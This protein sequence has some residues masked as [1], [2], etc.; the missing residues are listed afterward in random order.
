V[1]ENRVLRR[2]FVPKGSEVRGE[3]RKL[4][5]E[6]LNDQNS[7]ANISWVVRSR[8]TRWVGRVANMGKR[9]GA[10]TRRVLVGKREGKRSFGRFRLS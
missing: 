1:C 3:R 6:E 2:I 4:Y 9:R 7:I 8:R 10:Y 5:D